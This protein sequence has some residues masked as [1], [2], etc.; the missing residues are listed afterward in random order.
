MNL[1]NIKS[2]DF[3]GENYYPYVKKKSKGQ[4]EDEE[5]HNEGLDRTKRVEFKVIIDRYLRYFKSIYLGTDSEENVDFGEADNA[6]FESTPKVPNISKVFNFS[7]NL[8][9]FIQQ[10]SEEPITTD[11]INS[12]ISLIDY[13]G[14]I[15]FRLPKL[16]YR[17]PEILAQKPS[18]EEQQNLI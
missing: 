12:F 6:N 10:Q 9:R 16:F 14:R 7:H 13:L 4:E 18:E 15:F 5:K 17:F 8:Q 11:Q 3:E 2:P 1:F